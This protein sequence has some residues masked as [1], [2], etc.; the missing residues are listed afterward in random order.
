MSTKTFYT[1]QEVADLLKIKKTT[2]YELI[3]KKRL[4]SSKVGKQLRISQ[5]DLDMY[6]NQNSQSGNS[7]R[8]GQ[9][10]SSEPMESPGNAELLKMTE[11]SG[12][13]PQPVLLANTMDN[14]LRTR[15]YLRNNNGLIISGQDELI[16]VF[17]AYFQLELESLPVIQHSLTAY[18]SLYSLYF[19]KVH[20]AFV[21]ILQ[22]D[23]ACLRHLVP[24]VPLVSVQV[25]QKEYGFYVRKEEVYAGAA[26]KKILQKLIAS[27]AR[28]MLGEKGSICRMALDCHMKELGIRMEELNI[29][30][31]ESISSMAAAAA[32]DSGQAD[33]AVGS[34]SMGK[35][36][37]E[38]TFV[39]LYK[40]NL[41]L[42]FH[43]K[44]L[45]YPA[46]ESMIR[47]LQSDGFKRRL[48]QMDGYGCVKTG[49]IEYI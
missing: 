9:Y 4:P 42:I 16:S 49:E 25:A 37:P 41:K 30:P 32:V 6:L 33:A 38:L 1:A 3:K 23:E 31:R 24:G 2:V 35:R 39:P 7:G 15:D 48:A 28:V 21:P 10:V 20:A 29:S 12:P 11:N 46:F 22:G 5:A 47:V 45:N 26:V 36:F 17:C 8:A 14:A 27:D 13:A 44:F 43:R 40:A 19:E 34:S 18:D